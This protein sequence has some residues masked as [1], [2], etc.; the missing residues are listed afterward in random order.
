MGVG[1]VGG[2]GG[3]AEQIVGLLLTTTAQNLV[4]D[5]SLNTEDN[6]S[7]EWQAQH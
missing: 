1:D 4:L 2:W 7:V 3:G 5:N 6:E